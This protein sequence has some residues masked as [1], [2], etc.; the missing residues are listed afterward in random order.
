LA[1]LFVQEGVLA[2]WTDLAMPTEVSICLDGAEASQS[3]VFS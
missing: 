2:V 1:G 3:H